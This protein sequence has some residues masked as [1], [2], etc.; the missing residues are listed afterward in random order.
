HY[1]TAN[2]TASAGSDF[3]GVTDAVATIHAGEMF[4]DITIVVTADRTKESDEWFALNLSDVSSNAVL[5]DDQAIGWILD[6]DTRGKG[7]P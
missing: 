5:S 1:S 4:V 2:G 6:D 7:K 3:T